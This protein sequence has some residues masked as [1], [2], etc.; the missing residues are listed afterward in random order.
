M[1]F[2]DS[3][4]QDLVPSRYHVTFFGSSFGFS[5]DS[6]SSSGSGIGILA[7][8]H[9]VYFDKLRTTFMTLI[10]ISFNKSCTPDELVDSNTCLDAVAMYSVLASR[11]CQESVRHLGSSENR[12]QED[13]KTERTLRKLLKV[14]RSDGERSLMELITLL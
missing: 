9:T 12:K 2:V 1:Q 11:T 3:R 8:P 14:T 7:V 13:V 10:P 6:A 5:I 4:I